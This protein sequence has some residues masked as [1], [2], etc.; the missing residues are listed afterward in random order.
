MKKVFGKESDGRANSGNQEIRRR[1]EGDGVP[2][3]QEPTNTYNA[4]RR[5]SKVKETEENA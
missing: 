1:T 3:H 4:Q 5:S 2:E